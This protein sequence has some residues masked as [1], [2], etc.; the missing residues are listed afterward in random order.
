M[1][2]LIAHGAD[3]EGPPPS[4]LRSSAVLTAISECSANGNRKDDNAHWVFELVEYPNASSTFSHSPLHVAVIEGCAL[5][6]ETLLQGGA[7]PNKCGG[8]GEEFLHLLVLL[9]LENLA[10]L[11]NFRERMSIL[12]KHGASIEA[13]HSNGSQVLHLLAGHPYLGRPTDE[14][15]ALAVFL[16]EHGAKFEAKNACGQTA[17]DIAKDRGLTQLGELFERM[18]G[19]KRGQHEDEAR[20]HRYFGKPRLQTK[21]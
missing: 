13:P 5:N 12:L 9:S 1:N 4:A 20:R 17:Q 19:A 14:A 18:S 6:V 11:S 15:E 10:D 21:R 2:L 7:D 3:V 16:V 8:L